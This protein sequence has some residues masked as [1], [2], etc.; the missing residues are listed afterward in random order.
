M[1]W[2]LLYNRRSLVFFGGIVLVLG[3]L[4]VDDCVVAGD[5]IGLNPVTVPVQTESQRA[6][7]LNLTKNAESDSIAATPALLQLFDSSEFRK[8]ISNLPV[9]NMSSSDLLLLLNDTLA[10]SPITHGV[11]DHTYTFVVAL[12]DVT[13]IELTNL[14]FLPNVW[15]R[16]PLNE[17]NLTNP[18]EQ[19]LLLVQNIV[20]TRVFG[21]PDFNT[22]DYA[23]ITLEEAQGRV[24]YGAVNLMRSSDGTQFYG[25]VQLVLNN[26]YLTE[27]TVL[28]PFDTGNYCGCCILQNQPCLT[29]CNGIT[30]GTLKHWNHLFLYLQ[31]YWQLPLSQLFQRLFSVPQSNL[32]LYEQAYYFEADIMGNV[33][34]PEGVNYVIGDFSLLFGRYYGLVLQ[35][36]CQTNN[37]PLVWSLGIPNVN[38]FVA[39]NFSSSAPLNQSFIDPTTVATSRLNNITVNSDTLFEFDKLW[40]YTNATLTLEPSE[41]QND[42]FWWT[43]WGTTLAEMPSSLHFAYQRPGDCS[44]SAG[45]FGVDAD[46]NCICPQ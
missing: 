43:L 25:T 5:K 7:F 12:L 34:F 32:T 28:S 26:S 8:N 6:A 29:K 16:I 19:E 33:L 23:N 36:W 3:L 1:D 39:Q 20:E 35:Q 22:T 2:F 18:I 13:M 41:Q 24:G 37:W 15:E 46:G 31:N 17:L 42:N 38:S 14:T 40:E 4:V 9:A 11:Y 21:L 45:C 27:I 44:D 30:F 10:F